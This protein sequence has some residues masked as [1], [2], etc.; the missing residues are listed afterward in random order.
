VRA[1]DLGLQRIL[2]YGTGPLDPTLIEHGLIGESHFSVRP[3]ALGDGRRF[4]DLRGTTHLT[5]AG[6]TT[7]NT[8]V[9]VGPTRR[10]CAPRRVHPVVPLPDTPGAWTSGPQGS[11]RPPRWRARN[12]SAAA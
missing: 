9:V 1:A 5:P 11:A 12:S 4:E 7:I 8:G 3:V 2:R 6:A 10:R